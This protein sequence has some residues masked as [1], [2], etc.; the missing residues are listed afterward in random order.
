MQNFNGYHLTTEI[1]IK[2]KEKI[3]YIKNY[4]Y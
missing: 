1:S 2:F 3:K 4:I